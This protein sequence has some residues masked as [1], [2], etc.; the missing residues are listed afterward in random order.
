VRIE[1]AG[2]WAPLRTWAMA[3]VAT[4]AVSAIAGSLLTVVG[5][6]DAFAFGNTLADP[7][8]VSGTGIVVALSLAAVGLL[9]LCSYLL[10]IP[11][12]MV[13][14]YKAA[15]N[16]AALGRAG[17]QFS[18]ASQIWWYFVPFANLVQPY[19]AMQELYRASVLSGAADGDPDLDVGGGVQSW[20]LTVAPPVLLGWWL[21]HLASNVVQNLSFR[22]GWSTPSSELAMWLDAL[23]TPLLL[24]A[25]GLYMWLVWRITDAQHALHEA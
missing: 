24:V 23:A 20:Q 4:Q 12:W 19:R 13:W 18:P 10:S 9:T 5:L 6:L 1:A 16:L 22:I 25:T 15:N 21:I 7:D 17:M 11:V 8:D 2:G 14:H 3:V